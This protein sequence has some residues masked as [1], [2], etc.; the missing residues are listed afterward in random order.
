MASQNGMGFFM[1]SK[2]WSPVSA[3]S[4]TSTGMQAPASVINPCAM[5]ATSTA[6]PRPNAALF[7][8]GMVGAP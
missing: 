8:R 4:M 6:R 2:N 3:A 5:T 1:H 7:A